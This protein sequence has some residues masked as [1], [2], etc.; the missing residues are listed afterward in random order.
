MKISSK[1]RTA[2]RIM[3]DIA[4]NDEEFVS[5]SEI[6]KRQKITIKYLEQIISKLVK[7]KLLVSQRGV[8]GGY[9]LSKEPK[10]YSIAQILT[11]TNDMP[12]LAPCQES[13]KPCLQKTEC[14]T[15]GCWEE[16][17][18]IIFEFLENLSLQDLIDK[19]YKR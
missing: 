17:S 14:S 3:V 19:T 16:L 1:G 15:I 7:A 4:Q 6:S 12:R 2:V 5:I 9:K 10:D 8:M 11:V 18:K 13:D